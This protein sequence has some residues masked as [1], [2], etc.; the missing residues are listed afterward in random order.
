MRRMISFVLLLVVLA[1]MNAQAVGLNT[2]LVTR[3]ALKEPPSLEVILARIGDIYKAQEY[4]QKI[5][6]ET[7][8]S[9]NSKWTD[10]LGVL[11]KQAADSIIGELRKRGAYSDEMRAVLPLTVYVNFGEPVVDAAEKEG[12]YPNLMAAVASLTGTDMTSANESY[13]ALKALEKEYLDMA[14]VLAE[15]QNKYQTTLNPADRDSILEQRKLIK[16][17]KKKVKVQ[18]KDFVL[19]L[20]TVLAGKPAAGADPALQQAVYNALSYAYRL[21]ESAID[22]AI[23]VGIQSVK[24]IPEIPNEIKTLGPRLIQDGVEG[25]KQSFSSVTDLSGLSTEDFA[26][27]LLSQVRIGEGGMQIDMGGFGSVIEADD[28]L[29]ALKGLAPD[30]LSQLLDK[31]KGDALAPLTD[32]ISNAVKAPERV[33]KSI[34]LVQFNVGLLNSLNQDKVT[35]GKGLGKSIIDLPFPKIK[36]DDRKLKKADSAMR[37]ESEAMNRKIANLSPRNL[38]MSVANITMGYVGLPGSNIYTENYNGLYG[39]GDTLKYGED[40][41]KLYAPG[42]GFGV[43]MLVCLTEKSDFIRNALFYN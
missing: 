12:T 10:A 37:A 11:P 22:A 42:R 24:V 14:G 29:S 15:K 33:T 9:P 16:A 4:T 5:L 40:N 20:K 17:A 25:V 41:D 3:K 23:A 1:A 7:P 8:I 26:K 34:E 28:K 27:A 6:F 19:K 36:L 31:A 21:N 18:R 38:E 30:V 32:L 39:F 2:M 13:S 35:G 43:N